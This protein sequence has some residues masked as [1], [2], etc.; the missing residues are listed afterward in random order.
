MEASTL[1][2][3]R[4]THSSDQTTFRDLGVIDD[5]A[6]AL[7]AEGIVAPFPIQSMALPLALTGADIIG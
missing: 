5:I 7:E 4:S 2:T 1:T 3:V 6:D